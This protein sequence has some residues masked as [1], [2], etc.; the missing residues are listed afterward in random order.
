MSSRAMFPFLLP[1]Y[2]PYCACSLLIRNSVTLWIIKSF[3]GRRKKEFSLLWLSSSWRQC[4]VTTDDIKYNFL[5]FF[6]AGLFVH[7]L[8]NSTPKYRVSYSAVIGVEQRKKWR[9]L[10]SQILIQ[11]RTRKIR[12]LLGNLCDFLR[13]EIVDTIVGETRLYIY[14]FVS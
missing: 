12:S 11:I 5:V 13:G 3:S 8:T 2:F 4:R 6:L 10:V 9:T 14:V 7:V 1:Y